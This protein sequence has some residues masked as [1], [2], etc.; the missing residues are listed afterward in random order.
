MNGLAE[1]MQPDIMSLL[2]LLILSLKPKI[3]RVW[4]KECASLFLTITRRRN[5]LREAE[6]CQCQCHCVSTK[7]FHA[8]SSKYC[9]GNYIPTSI[10]NCSS[11][12]SFK[13]HLKSH[14]IAQLISN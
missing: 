3:H 5:I 6:G 12:Y 10:N 1:H 4:I 7:M 14:L 8:A 13:R 11:L 2:N 9:S